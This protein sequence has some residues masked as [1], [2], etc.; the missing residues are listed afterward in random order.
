MG[1]I[2]ILNSYLNSN[3]NAYLKFLID[4]NA[5]HDSMYNTFQIE[6]RRITSLEFSKDQKECLVTCILSGKIIFDSELEPCKIGFK[7]VVINSLTN[8]ILNRNILETES[9]EIFN[10]GLYV[11]FIKANLMEDLTKEVDVALTQ[12]EDLLSKVTEID[13]RSL[14]PFDNS[15][16]KSE[17]LE[18]IKDIISGP[19]ADA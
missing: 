7:F 18:D 14:N 9:I 13:L 12:L 5:K 17:E 1:E 16:D 6:E 8:P 19:S 15:E 10:S 11:K 2:K 4:D 3:I